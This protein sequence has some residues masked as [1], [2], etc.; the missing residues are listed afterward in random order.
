MQA[1]ILTGGKGTRLQHIYPDVPKAL[2]PVNGKPFIQWQIEWLKQYDMTDIHLALGHKSKAIL[3][4][5]GEKPFPDINITTSIEPEPLGTA[6][7]L[8]FALQS[9]NKEI[10]MTLNGDTLLPNLNLKDLITDHLESTLAVTIVTIK[11]KE[12]DRFGTIEVDSNNIIKSF[13]EKVPSSN[14]WINGGIYIFSSSALEHL[15]P[16][17]QGSL[18]TDVFP[19]MCAHKILR[20][21][22]CKGP[23]LD[24]GTP[25]GLSETGQFLIDDPIM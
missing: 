20:A 11:T 22:P 24:M 8:N 5:L 18:E 2:V 9:V 3:E 10:F 13:H 15:E 19:R 12:A 4:W 14:A 21:F 7:G 25:E 6:G 1:I 16:W 23:L 17:P